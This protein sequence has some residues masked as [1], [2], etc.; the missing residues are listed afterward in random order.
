MKYMVF[1][2]V[3]LFSTPVFAN[4]N[5]KAIAE[6]VVHQDQL[7]KTQAQDFTARYGDANTPTA[8]ASVEV[9]RDFGTRLDALINTVRRDIDAMRWLIDH[10]CGPAK[11]EPNAIKSVH[12]MQSMLIALIVRRMDARA[13]R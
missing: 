5:C 11:E 10:H 1:P 3:L 13:L 6:D 8:D 4:V 9:R 7:F 12:D 2:L